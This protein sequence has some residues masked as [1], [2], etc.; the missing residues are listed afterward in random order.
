MVYQLAPLATLVATL[1][2]LAVLAKNNE[3]IAFK[4]SGVSL[5]RIVLPLHARRVPDRGRDVFA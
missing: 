4:A 3:V 1:V 2:T 5:Y